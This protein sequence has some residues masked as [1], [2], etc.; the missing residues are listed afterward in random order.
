VAVNLGFWLAYFVR[1]NLGRVFEKPMFGYQI[2]GPFIVFANIVFVFSFAFFG[3]YG[4]SSARDSGSDLLLR[5]FRA[6]FVS[7]VILM[8]S[9]FLTSQ[10]VY[11][12][13]LVGVFCV[14]TIVLATVFRLFLRGVHRRVRAGRFDL[15][16]V[17]IVGTGPTALR[18]GRRIVAH[19]ELGYDLAG[20]VA[21]GDAPGDVGLPVMGSLE[22]LPRLIDEQRVGEVI[23][24]DP[25]LP[26][27]TVADFL[28]TARRSTV[29]V[30]M[31]SGL[32]GILTQRAKVEEFLDMPVVS[33]EREALLRA[34]AGAKRV[35]DVVLSG[36]LIAL[37]SPALA[38]TALVTAT[39]GARPFTS[40][41]RAG[42]GAEPFD[43]YAPNPTDGPSAFRRFAERHGLS[44]APSLLNVWKGQMS[45]VGPTPVPPERAARFEGRERLRFDARPG[46]TGLS[47]VALDP[48]D[49]EGGDPAALDVY[50]VQ[51]WSLGGDVRILLRWLTR[52]LG[53]GCAQKKNRKGHP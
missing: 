28:M 33:F 19:R 21:V 5:V 39:R 10:T 45:L 47:Q 18:L 17:A 1:L 49:E 36:V 25:D 7:S 12:R 41:S 31:V 20:L 8:A 3:L 43:M 26:G 32:S 24:G 9:T 22:D 27:D 46:I 23:F 2:Y 35:V 50:Y 34:G 15:T 37:W 14:L 30:K 52:C 42:L 44:S 6:T 40:S 38:L 4:G 13:V 51:N 11:S 16:R 53:G 29:D 48:G